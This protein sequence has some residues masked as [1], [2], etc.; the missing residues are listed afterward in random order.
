ML[1]FAAVACAMLW[2]SL[3][4]AI[5]WDFDDGTTQ[6]WSAK[7]AAIWG[8][9]RELHLFSGVV[10]DG[11][12]RIEVDPSVTKGFYSRP[13]VEVISSTI[14]YDSGLFDQV[15][16]R[17][18]TVHHSPTVGIFA[19]EWTNEHNSMASGWDPAGPFVISRFGIL[20]QP[21]VYTTEWQEVVISLTDQDEKIW[22]GSVKRY[23][24]SFCTGYRAG[25]RRPPVGDR[26]G[27]GV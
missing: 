16:I 7:E 6:G 22:G 8:G 20:P 15:R 1:K 13:S 24:A 19:I 14:G 26:C 17:F 23:S 18:R 9:S 10:E 27:R 11:V 5:R 3:A 2:S 21:I 12:W 25:Y 4:E